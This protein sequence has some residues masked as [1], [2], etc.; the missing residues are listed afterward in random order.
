MPAPESKAARAI[1]RYLRGAR[2]IEQDWM[3]AAA[4]W[5]RGAV[6]VHERIE[7]VD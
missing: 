7:D 3:K 5:R 4:Y 1:R 6:G 2:A